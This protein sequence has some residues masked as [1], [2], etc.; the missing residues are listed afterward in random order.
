MQKFLFVNPEKCSGCRICET[1]CSLH[2]EKVCNP[3]RARVQVIKW[4]SIGLYIPIIC[5][6]CDVPICEEVCPMS[7]V[8]KNENTGALLIDYGLCV[9]CRL[10]VS[11]CPFGGVAIDIDSKVKKCDLCDGD[12]QCVK[13]CEPE[14]LQYIEATT[15]NLMKRKAAAE[16]FS[17]LMKKMVILVK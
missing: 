1:V 2:H 4:E 11:H 14:A 9:G 16:R 6:Q 7:A 13:N 3:G 17:E 8:H 10:C 15:I 5:H 12:P